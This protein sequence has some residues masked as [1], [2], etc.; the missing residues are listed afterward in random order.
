M[1][2]QKEALASLNE[3]LQSDPANTAYRRTR[4]RVL[5]RIGRQEDAKRE[6]KDL[7]SKDADAQSLMNLG[8][9]YWREKNYD[10]AWKIAS[11]LVKLDDKNPAFLRFMANMEI[12]RMNY[13]QALRLSQQALSLAPAD[14]DTKLTLSKALFRMQRENDALAILQ[15]LIVQYPDNPAVEYRWAEFLYRTG[16]QEA[17]LPF[18]DRLIKADP[19]NETYR[20][21]RGEALYEL[22]RF[23]AAV[24]EWS[25]L[26]SQREPNRYAVRLLRDDAFNRRDWDGAAVWQKKVIADDPSDP[27]AREKLS[28]IY[29]AMKRLPEAL[30]AAE[31][32]IAA[33]PVSIN[34]YYMKGDI[35]VQMRNSS[36]AMG[37]YEDVLKRN[38]N[39]TR[40]LDG[41][42][43]VFEAEGRYDE[44]LKSL[45]RVEALTAPAVSAF[46]ELHQARL[47]ADSDHFDKAHKILRRIETGFGTPIPVLLYHGI[48]TFDRGDSIPKEALRNQLSALKRKGYQ[49][50]T[51]SELERVFQGKARLPE[52]PLLIT[53]D[54]GRTDTFENAD[55]ILKDLGLRATMFVHLSKLRKT[56]F[57][58]GP[59]DIL[60]WQATGR[61]EMQAHGYQAHDPLPLDGFGRKGH[62]LANRMW[63]ADADRLETLAEYRGRIADDYEKAKQGVEDI[64]PGHEV[65]A[66]AYP[67][68]DYGQND[69]SNTPESPAINQALVKKTFRLAFV[70]DQDGI[71]ALSSNPTDLR[72]YAVPRYMTAQQL[73]SHLALG[74]P[75]V[76]AKLLEA[77]LWIRADQLGRAQA[78]FDDLEAGG[79]D[80]S[81]LWAGEGA[82]FQ[83]GGDIS[84]ARNLFSRAAAQEPDKEG[85]DAEQDK[86][87]S[88]QAAHA[89]APVV[90][91]EVQGFTDSDTNAITKELLLGSDLIKSVR[92]GAWVGHGYYLD[93]LNPPGKPPHIE[94]EEGGVQLHWFADRKLDLDGFYVRRAFLEGEGSS[95]NYSIA[96]AYQLVPS[97]KLA[98]RDGMGNVETAAAIREARKFHSDGAGAVWDPALNWRASAD[99]DDNRFN[100]SNWEQD[101]R[102]RVTKRF[103]DWIS[104]GAAYFNGDS[105]FRAPDYYTPVGLNQYTGVITL[106]Q[107]LGT[108]NPRTGLAPAQGELQ[109]EGGYGFQPVGSSMVNSV[110]AILTLRPWDRV[111][112]SLDGEYAQSPEYISRLARGTVSVSF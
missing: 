80:E 21:D 1:G 23:D 10:D 92:I 4:A 86:K 111:A 22:G 6:W 17:S 85:L 43:Y 81:R 44:A 72:R 107:T 32:A 87:L 15:Q 76:Q 71:N 20:L 42:S 106:N 79:V 37:A 54:D 7:T 33:D 5:S 93:R 64:V 84:Y 46:L 14:R 39:S 55:P 58:A 88:T 89:A 60:R 73:T 50:I 78:V 65:V 98:A 8:W 9:A 90:S 59:D 101:I 28:K 102:L 36:A 24:S 57:H 105:R 40:A 26:A 11:I 41:M 99:Y 96:A 67:Y 69:Y 110:K 29:V 68:G 62:F 108:I 95:D 30:R 70:Q 53:F 34:A 27:I 74:D 31:Q 109:Y 82:A 49:T 83:K 18:F 47:L 13:P 2:R 75:R 56:H 103:T 48:S 94:S 66:F 25:L 52:K 16:R 63:L 45:Q 77:Q 91:A 61:W 100:D 12:E 97:L 104:C 3:L 51:V 19:S 35:L 38:P 112:L